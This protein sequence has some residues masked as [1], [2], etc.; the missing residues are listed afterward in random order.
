[1]KKRG[2]SCAVFALGLCVS[3]AAIAQEQIWL[4]DR[5]YTEGVGVR[6]GD[7]EIHPGLAGEFGYDSNYFLTSDKDTPKPI[8]SL[9]LRITPSLSL[10]T[11]SR[12]RRETDE[13]GEPPKVTFRAGVAATYN[14]FIATSGNQE[15]LTKQRS[16]G[17]SG[18]LQLAIL[19]Q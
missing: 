13:G 17:G 11:L 5:R 14:E 15:A 10:S 8:P 3:T 7:L 18:S 19:P 6:A 1:M 16:V 9:R 4:K 12:Q 2:L